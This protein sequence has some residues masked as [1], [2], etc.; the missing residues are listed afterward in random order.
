MKPTK[1]AILG[2]KPGPV[3]TSLPPEAQ[4]YIDEELNRIAGL[5]A[6][7]LAPKA[8]APLSMLLLTPLSEPPPNPAMPQ[9]VYADGVSWDPGSGAG[10]YYWNEE[11][12]TP[13]G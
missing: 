4:R 3:P 12:W 9:I 2:Y 13:L 10:F 7:L 6:A 11:V 8:S 5:L 1:G